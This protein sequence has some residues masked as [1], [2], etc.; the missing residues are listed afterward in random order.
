VVQRSGA[1]SS[2]SVVGTPAYRAPKLWRGTPPARTASVC[3]PPS[4]ACARPASPSALRTPCNC[5]SAS[6]SVSRICS[7][8][9]PRNYPPN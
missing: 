7:A 2:M 9:V 5:P 3:F 6:M 4:A 8:S 1:S